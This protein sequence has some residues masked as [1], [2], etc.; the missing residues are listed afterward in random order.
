MLPVR[1]MSRL[2]LLA[3]LITGLHMPG[4][5][6]M[7]STPQRVEQQLIWP[8]LVAGL[9]LGGEQRP[10]VRRFIAEYRASPA[11][12]YQLLARSE[13][14]LA[15]VLKATE[16]RGLPAEIALLPTVESAWDPT[17]V[18]V[19]S[20]H[21]LWQFIAKTGHDYGLKDGDNY[22][23]RQDPV[24]STKAALNLLDDLHR[25]YRDWP[26]ALAAY[27][28]GGVRLKAAMQK[29]NSRDFWKLP[30]PPHTRNYVPRLLAIAA[31]I[32]DPERYGLSLPPIA[33]GKLPETV[34]WQAD[35][36]LRHAIRAAALDEAVLRTYNP[37]VAR[38][39][40][41]T[42]APTLLLPAAD[43][44]QV[45]AELAALIEASQAATA[46]N[47]APPRLHWHEQLHSLSSPN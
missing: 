30:L 41:P 16:Q 9:R 6:A 21:G 39:D 42:A 44:L 15:M 46:L 32:R 5:Q 2:L 19:S 47:T 3:L 12:F 17:A 38:M 45:K 37:A 31:L 11:H 25:A 4:V 40:L 27:N 35:T 43:A 1:A 23:A 18:S 14:F 24:A 20:A 26:L 33:E 28:A 34:H 8:R 13:P 36:P 7:D 10:E 29:R 22:N